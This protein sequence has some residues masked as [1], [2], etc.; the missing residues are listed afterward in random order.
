MKTT[1]LGHGWFA[2]VEKQDGAESVTIRNP[3]KGLRIDLPPAS[4]E[5]LR[6]ALKQ[7]AAETGAA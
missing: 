4:V 1:D 3:D 6:G 5:R 7:A 2:T